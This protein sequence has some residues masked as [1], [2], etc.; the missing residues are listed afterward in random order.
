[1]ADEQDPIDI[2]VPE[3]PSGLDIDI[4]I[5]KYYHPPNYAVVAYVPAALAPE[6]SR[7]LNAR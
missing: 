4:E 5:L 6:W 1:M 2:E 7:K 3:A